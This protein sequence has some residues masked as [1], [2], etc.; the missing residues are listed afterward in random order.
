[1]SV[2]KYCRVP[3][4]MPHKLCKE[5]TGYSQ[6]DSMTAIRS[7]K[8]INE[9]T[10]IHAIKSQSKDIYKLLEDQMHWL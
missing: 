4:D 10:T 5:G 9:Q 2:Y 6:S 3:F 7:N 1:M 8:Q